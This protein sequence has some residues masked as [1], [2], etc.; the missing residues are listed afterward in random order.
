MEQRLRQTVTERMDKTRLGSEELQCKQSPN[1][2][3]GDGG[4]LE[5]QGNLVRAEYRDTDA[6]CKC[7]KWLTRSMMTIGAGAQ[8]VRK[9]GLS[10]GRT[11]VCADGLCTVAGND[12]SARNRLCCDLPSGYDGY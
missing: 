11:S 4:L 7:D 6:R 1:P 12:L 10:R 3:Q 9:N 8:C 5:A 2:E